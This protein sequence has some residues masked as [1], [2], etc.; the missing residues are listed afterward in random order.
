MQSKESDDTPCSHPY[1]EYWGDLGWH[2]KVCKSHLEDDSPEAIRAQTQKDQVLK[3]DADAFFGDADRSAEASFHRGVTVS[4]LVSWTNAHDCWDMPTW[5]VCLDIITKETS[6]YLCRYVELAEHCN[7]NTFDS[8]DAPE[9]GPSEVFISHAWGARWGNLVGACAEILNSDT[10]VWIDLFAVRQWPGNIADLDFTGVVKRCRSFVVVIPS[11]PALQ[12]KDSF[13]TRENLDLLLLPED[14]KRLPFLR[15][16]CLVEIAVAVVQGLPVICMGGTGEK[17]GFQHDSN[18]LHLASQCIDV[19]NAEATNPVDKANLKPMLSKVTGGAEAMNRLVRSLLHGAS[20][21]NSEQNG[22]VGSPIL[23]DAAL[24]TM[25]CLQECFKVNQHDDEMLHELL[26]GAAAGGFIPATRYLL[27]HNVNPNFKSSNSDKSVMGFAALGGSIECL[28]LLL[29]AGVDI[30]QTHLGGFTPFIFAAT[31]DHAEVIIY[32]FEMGADVDID[33]HGSNAGTLYAEETGSMRAYWTISLLLEIHRLEK[34]VFGLE[35]NERSPEFKPLIR[36]VSRLLLVTDEEDAMDAMMEM[37]SFHDELCRMMPV[38]KVLMSYD[39]VDVEHGIDAKIIRPFIIR[40]I[41]AGAS[42]DC[43]GSL[44]GPGVVERK[45][46]CAIDDC[47]DSDLIGKEIEPLMLK[48][49]ETFEQ[50]KL[51]YEMHWVGDYTRQEEEVAVAILFFATGALQQPLRIEDAMDDGNYLVCAASNGYRHLCEILL[52]I[53]WPYSLECLEIMHESE[54]LD[55]EAFELLEG[56]ITQY[57][58]GEV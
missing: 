52:N 16:W 37:E 7:S 30:N 18:M 33:V 1:L 38:V 22:H 35:S 46:V 41:V 54:E 48:L 28:E 4:W 42:V 27:E 36:K 3:R 29:N 20:K 43:F 10:R 40:A 25:K 32:L 34:I 55:T 45:E 44:S 13:Y 57:E 5:K 6:P 51:P 50:G 17:D 15:Y 23:A 2:C 21:C 56:L 9:A 26:C 19:E 47:Y 39:G 53:G 58:G 24:G 11:L 8:L 49:V 12:G 31:R 14:R